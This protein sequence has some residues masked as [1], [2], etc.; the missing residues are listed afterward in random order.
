MKIPVGSLISP[1][2]RCGSGG[3]VAKCKI[4]LFGIYF[5]GIWDENRSGYSGG[6]ESQHLLTTRLSRIIKNGKRKVLCN[7]LILIMINN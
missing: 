1:H 6:V 5:A 7:P 2:Y 3:D 4:P